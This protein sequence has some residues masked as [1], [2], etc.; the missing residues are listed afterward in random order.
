[1][2]KFCS[3]IDSTGWNSLWTL[4]ICDW[5]RRR[6]PCLCSNN[7]GETGKWLKVSTGTHPYQIFLQ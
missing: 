3:S 7:R 5:K 2:K 6:I 1:M 4:Q